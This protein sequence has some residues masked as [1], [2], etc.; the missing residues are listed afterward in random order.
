MRDLD[1]AF[2][3]VVAL[4][5]TLIL[6]A[7]VWAAFDFLHAVGSARSVVLVFASRPPVLGAVPGFLQ[8]QRGTRPPRHPLPRQQNDAWTEAREKKTVRS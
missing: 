4:M 7:I 3:I 1:L 5:I 2:V 8:T 6:L